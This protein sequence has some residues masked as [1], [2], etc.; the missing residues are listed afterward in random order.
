MF[1]A[2]RNV[3]VTKSMGFSSQNVSSL[4]TVIRGLH[5]LLGSSE[6]PPL[7]SQML[8][9][10]G[11]ELPQKIPA[12]LQERWDQ[13]QGLQQSSPDLTSIS[14]CPVKPW[15]QTTIRTKRVLWSQTSSKTLPF[16]STWFGHQL[17]LIIQQHLTHKCSMCTV[18]PPFLQVATRVFLTFVCIVELGQDAG[19]EDSECSLC[20]LCSFRLLPNLVPAQIKRFAGL[21][22]TLEAVWSA[23]G[24]VKN[25]TNTFIAV[26]M[27]G[28]VWL[29]ACDCK[30]WVYIRV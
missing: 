8:R 10:G 14:T 21:Q 9:S 24:S 23:D 29:T 26:Y 28:P 4:V 19:A 11:M 7:S 2:Y 5:T 1:A 18:V 22:M 20:C 25:P 15:I 3:S 13:N 6:L 27:Q 12:A 30:F 16:L 17:G